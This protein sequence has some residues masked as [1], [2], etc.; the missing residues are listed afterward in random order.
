MTL[1]RLGSAESLNQESVGRLLLFNLTLQ[2]DIY[3]LT[4]CQGKVEVQYHSLGEAVESSRQVEIAETGQLEFVY[5]TFQSF[6]T[7]SETTP[8]NC[9]T[10]NE[11]N[12]VKSS[13]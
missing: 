3:S 7:N 5:P 8:G 1:L 13:R 6:E 4:S 11:F 2:F 12:H 9:Q 10:I